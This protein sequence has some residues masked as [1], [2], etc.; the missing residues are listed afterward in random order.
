MAVMVGAMHRWNARVNLPVRRVR[1]AEVMVAAGHVLPVEAHQSAGV[2]VASTK[3]TAVDRAVVVV[4]RQAGDGILM[5]AVVRDAGAENMR[6]MT[7]TFS[8]ISIPLL[9]QTSEPS[10]P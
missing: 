1:I 10:P 4:R 9:P 6:M 2:A 8:P 7:W 3:R 5:M